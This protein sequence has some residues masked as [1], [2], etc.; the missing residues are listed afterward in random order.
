MVMLQ[1]ARFSIAYGLL[2]FG[3]NLPLLYWG[4]PTVNSGVLSVTYAAIHILTLLFALLVGFEWLHWKGVV[5]AVIKFLGVV[6]IFDNA[7]SFNLPVLP[8]FAILARAVWAG[9][10]GLLFEKGDG[11]LPV[12][13]HVRADVPYPCCTMWSKY[14]PNGAPDT[15]FSLQP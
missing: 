4:L 12:F 9:I 13:A 15:L 3:I 11:E 5:G 14:D 7:L 2:Y 8:L 10:T 6:F 1:R